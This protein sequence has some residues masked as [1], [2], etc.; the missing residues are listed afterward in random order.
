MKLIVPIIGLFAIFAVASTDGKD[1]IKVVDLAEDLAKAREEIKEIIQR[2]NEKLNAEDVKLREEDEKIKKDANKIKKENQRLRKQMAKLR[3]DNSEIKKIQRQ[4]DQNNT[5]ELQHFL[6]DQ[7]NTLELQHFLK[8]SIRQRDVSSELK[9]L[10]KRQIDE[11]LQVNKICVAGK[12]H[13]SGGSGII[14]GAHTV[15]FGHTFPRVPT[16]TVSVSSFRI[17]SLPYTNRDLGA[18]VSKVAT[19]S[20]V[21]AV[22]ADS[23]FGGFSVAWMACL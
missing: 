3:R 4:K 17:D 8:D 1:D 9:K 20:A 21:V 13:K 23:N 6:K 7:N 19:S 14:N 2:E 11:Y 18:S 5:L 10:M 12:F 15:D 16:F 22:Y